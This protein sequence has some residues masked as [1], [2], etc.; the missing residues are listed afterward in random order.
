MFD[1]YADLCGHVC[2]E[3]AAALE[4]NPALLLCI[5]AGHTSLG[6]LDA[7][8]KAYRN[9]KADFSKAAFVAMDEWQGMPQNTPGSCAD[10]L[11]KNLLDH[12][13]F[14]PENIRLFDGAAADPGAECAAV[15]RF[16]QEHSREHCIDYLVLGSGMNGH[17]ALNEPGTPFTARAHTAAL[18]PVTQEVGQKYFT[19]ETKLEGGLTLGI[20]NFREA[21]RSVLIVNGKHK[22]DILRTILASGPDE[23]IPATAI[24][25]FPNGA[26]YYDKDAFSDM[27]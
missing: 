6:V 21:K 20:A 22:R 10:F 9:G 24:K 19:A 3:I 26:L 14:L 2:G 16:I 25:K 8:V 5:A 12:V 18:D 17:L 23:A 4:K 11:K 7:L 1:T 13:N 15:E 27:L